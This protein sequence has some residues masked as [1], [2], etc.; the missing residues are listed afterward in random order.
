M[1]LTAPGTVGSA[2]GKPRGSLGY[3]GYP[4]FWPMECPGYRFHAMP[5]Q[6][7]QN[8]TLTCPQKKRPGVR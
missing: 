7:I 2:A 8:L 1:D 6:W 5:R 4:L 3:T